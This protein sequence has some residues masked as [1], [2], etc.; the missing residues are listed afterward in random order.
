MIAAKLRQYAGQQ[1]KNIYPGRNNGSHGVDH[2]RNLIYHIRNFYPRRPV[3]QVV[4]VN[5]ALYSIPVIANRYSTYRQVL[6][7]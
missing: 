5:I 2:E 6:Q 1:R 7:L 3:M 4:T